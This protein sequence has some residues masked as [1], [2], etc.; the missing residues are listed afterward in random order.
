MPYF[1]LLFQPGGVGGGE[2]NNFGT[3]RL[4]IKMLAMRGQPWSLPHCSTGFDWV[5]R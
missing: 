5:T 2:N 1:S 4:H 3:F